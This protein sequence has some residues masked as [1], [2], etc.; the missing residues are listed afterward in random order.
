VPEECKTQRYRPPR[1]RGAA[2]R[3]QNAWR[4]ASISGCQHQVTHQCAAPVNVALPLG[5]STRIALVR[6]G[7]LGV[8]SIRTFVR[9]LF[10]RR[11]CPVQLLH[12]V[13]RPSDSAGDT[14]GFQSL[15]DRMRSP[16]RR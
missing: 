8:A 2:Y 4:L 15:P 1:R 12:R 3:V 11:R 9:G 13:Q 16:W 6:C 14:A 10:L 5:F 7:F